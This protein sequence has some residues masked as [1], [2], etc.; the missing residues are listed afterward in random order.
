MHAYGSS[1]GGDRP[2]SKAMD[3]PRIS[4][5]LEVRETATPEAHLRALYE[6]LRMWA[7]KIAAGLLTPIDEPPT[8]V[9]TYRQ[10]GPRTIIWDT[11]SDG[12]AW[13]HPSHRDEPIGTPDDLSGAVGAIAQALG[14][15]VR[16]M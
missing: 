4:D 8:L 2:R 10:L 5:D 14:A 7:P 3:A 13:E 16:T 9:V 12:F 15:P 1:R 6:E 11:D